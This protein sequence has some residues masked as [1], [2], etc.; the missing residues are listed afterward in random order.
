MPHAQRCTFFAPLLPC[1]AV[2]VGGGAHSIMPS[3][4]AIHADAFAEAD[5]VADD[6]HVAG[7]VAAAD[8]LAAVPRATCTHCLTM[9]MTS[10]PFS[11]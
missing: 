5:V 11:P 9:M 4:P 8:G 6:T 3:D 1:P 10:P 2:N 7:G